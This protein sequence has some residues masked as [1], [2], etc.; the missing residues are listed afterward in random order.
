MREP[1]V[2][3][4][5]TTHPWNV[6]GVGLDSIIAREYRVRALTVVAAVSAQDARGVHALEAIAPATLRAQLAAIPWE[7][8]DAMRVGALPTPQAITIV[9]EAIAAHATIRAVVDPVAAASLG[10]SLTEDGCLATLR[11][12]LATLANVIL[13]PNLHEAARLLGVPAIERAGMPAAAA[14]LRARGALAVLVKGGHTTGD[15]VDVLAYA[16]E[17][18]SFSQNRLPGQMRGTGCTLAMALACELAKGVPLLEAT[19]AARAFVR[20]KIL[21]GHHFGG[22]GTAY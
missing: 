12:Q 21:A 1:V 15:P 7:C 2:L 8:V 11:D 13:T 10:G 17:V 20:E 5:G 9:A 6:A 22:I 3:C 19:L 18:A 14:S 16:S 4:I